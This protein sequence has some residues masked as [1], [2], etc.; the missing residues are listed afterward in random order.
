[1]HG[2]QKL[3]FH[4]RDYQEF[5]YFNTCA[6]VILSELR[7]KVNVVLSIWE[8]GRKILHFLN[9]ITVLS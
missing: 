3:Q 2:K 9:E 1:M 6:I 5:F 4:L 7:I 8:C